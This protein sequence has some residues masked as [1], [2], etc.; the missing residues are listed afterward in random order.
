MGIDYKGLISIHGL[1]KLC[2]LVSIINFHY[3]VLS[4]SG[5]V[6]ID[7]W[8]VKHFGALKTLCSQ[9]NLTFFLGG[10]SYFW[11]YLI[12]AIIYELQMAK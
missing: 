7:N 5:P 2:E 6:P 3:K 1:F 4:S 11:N 9:K 12:Q 10:G 8:Q